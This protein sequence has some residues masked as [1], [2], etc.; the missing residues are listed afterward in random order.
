MKT[1]LETCYTV[2]EMAKRLQI[3]EASLRSHKMGEIKNQCKNYKWARRVYVD[4]SDFL[5]YEK[6]AITQGA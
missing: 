3:T 4:K 2:P 1:M 6:K 5:K